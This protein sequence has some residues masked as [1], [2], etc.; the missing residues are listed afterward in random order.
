MGDKFRFGEAAK[1]RDPI[2]GYISVPRPLVDNIIDTELG[3]RIKGVTQ[4]GM[5]PLFPSA[6]HDR[7]AHSLGVLKF[8]GL[9]YESLEKNVRKEAEKHHDAKELTDA[10]FDMLKADLKFWKWLLQIAALVHDIGHPV[11]SHAFEFLYDDI[12]FPFPEDGVKVVNMKD[13]AERKKWQ[14]RNVQIFNDLM[15]SNECKHYAPSESRLTHLLQEKLNL[16]SVRINGSP[17]ERMSAY[18]L[19][20]KN[21]SCIVLYKKISALIEGLNDE[22]PPARKGNYAE[23]AIVFICRMILGQEYVIP[24]LSHFDYCAF[25]YSVKNCIIAI[26]NGTIDADSIDYT[27]RNAFSAGY[28]THQVDYDRLCSAY[29]VLPQHNGQLVPCFNKSALSVLGGFTVARNA[30]PKWMYS[31]HKVVYHDVLIKTLFHYTAKYLNHLDNEKTGIDSEWTTY[32]NPYFSYLLAT[33]LPYIGKRFSSK[34]ATDAKI[35]VF[36]HDI[37]LELTYDTV[38]CSVRFNE[39]Q[40]DVFNGLLKEY[41]TRKFKH[42]LWKSYAEYYAFIRHIAEKISTTWEFVN[43]TF[44]RLI[45]KGLATSQFDLQNGAAVNKNYKDQ[46]IYTPGVEDNGFS[47]YLKFYQDDKL[48]FESANAGM[49]FC[50]PYFV[51]PKCVCKIF[52]GHFKNFDAVKVKVGDKLYKLGD[53][54]PSKPETLEF[55]YVFVQDESEQ[56]A[57]L[58]DNFSDR[59][60]CYC[61]RYL[62]D[63]KTNR[64]LEDSV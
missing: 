35:D 47:Q 26:I 18:L 32:E 60:T 15:K 45:R 54:V 1:F 21:D 17:H 37:L 9:M 23:R 49:V 4:T 64:L 3:Q 36:F 42:S 16:S 19:L 44:L 39:K 62:D 14:D 22:Y 13:D 30:E 8:S 40:R 27:I 38:G 53:F 59:L 5:R 51:Y 34:N 56:E 50:E 25:R 28:N 6:T 61:L 24:Y 10:Q 33:A 55:P 7:F 46:I 20:S 11:G 43:D 57:A 58:L 48:P 29:T 2:H 12:F 52:K 31:H 63:R 41:T